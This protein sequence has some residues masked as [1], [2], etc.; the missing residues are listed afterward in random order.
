VATATGGAPADIIVS[1]NGKYAYNVNGMSHSIGQYKIL[2][3]GRLNS[4]GDLPGLPVA[5]AG[6]VA[7]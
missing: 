1:D 5:A 3:N 4:L 2:P 6:I 7:W